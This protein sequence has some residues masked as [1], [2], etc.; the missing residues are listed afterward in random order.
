MTTCRTFLKS[1]A[2]HGFAGAAVVL[3]TLFVSL[4]C[5]I[6]GVATAPHAAGSL[7]EPMPSFA[8][9]MLAGFVIAAIASIGSFLASLVLT[10]LRSKWPFPGWIP[11]LVIPLLALVALL[12]LCGELRYTIF[13]ALSTVA[14]FLCFGIYWAVLTSRALLDFLRRRSSKEKA[15]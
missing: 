12:L 2:V 8:T 6:A 15:V 10:W 5:Y 3:T 9:W 11:V 7:L 14:V 1:L 13:I 4:L